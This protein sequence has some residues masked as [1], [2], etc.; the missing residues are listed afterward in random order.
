MSIFECLQAHALSL[1][2][3]GIG[4]A[5]ACLVAI[6]C[7]CPADAVVLMAVVLAASAVA[8]LATSC[9]RS[10]RFFGQLR[11]LTNELEHPYQLH[12]LV[13]EPTS[14]DQTIVFDALRAMGVASAEEVAQANAKA[15]EHREFVEGWV[16][17]V[18]AP[19]ASCELIAKRVSEPERSQLESELD[20]ISRKVDTALWYARSDCATQDY[21]IR[22]VPLADI[23]RKVCRDDARLLIEHGCMPQIGIDESL[24]VLTDRKQAVFIVSQLVENAAKYGAHHVR[25][26]AARNGVD[27]GPG[28]IDLRVED[29]GRGI[30]AAEVGRVFERGFTGTRGRE[31]ASSTGMGL[32]LAARL[33]EQLCLG[34]SIASVDGEG[35]CATVSFPLDRRQLDVQCDTFERLP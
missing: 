6:V 17:D 3:A 2:V 32:Y 18:K 28:H 35:T 33:C 14:P 23:P 16:H 19:L 1:L 25:F 27:G 5:S 30:P 22:E 24:R 9:L 4:G 15:R 13:G 7:G 29:D 10:R 20:R 11:R 34:L 12:S 26:S 8:A 31:G 21:A